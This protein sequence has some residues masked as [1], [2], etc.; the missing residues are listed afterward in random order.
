MT[1]PTSPQICEGVSPV[2]PCDSSVVGTAELKKMAAVWLR[3]HF[4]S[5]K[6]LWPLLTRL[7]LGS[8]VSH[9]G[10][11]FVIRNDINGF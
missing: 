6:H 11:S 7:V 10:K 4:T 5:V 1:L 9:M 2:S 3:G 8:R